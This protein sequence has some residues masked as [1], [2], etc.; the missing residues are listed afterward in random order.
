MNDLNL[1]Q[2]SNLSIFLLMSLILILRY[3]ISSGVFHYWSFTSHKATGPTFIK[4]DIWRS[5]QSSLVFAAV[6]TVFI[7]ML[8]NG[9]TQVYFN[10]S[11]FAWWYGPLSLILFLILQDTYFYWTHRLMH[12]YSFKKYHFAHHESRHPTAWTSFAFH[13]LEALI[14]AIFLPLFVAVIPIHIAYF[15]LALF[16]MTVFGITNHL[17][18]EIYPLALEKKLYI[19]T[20][21]HHNRHHH[22]VN[23]NFGLFFTFWDLLMGTE[24]HDKN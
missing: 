13:P 8:K 14:Q 19:I 21:T 24:Y 17:G 4:K 18:R 2:L 10:F 7:L 1:P 16:I 15:F 22:V 6:S 12:V 23:K 11:D 3:F 20:S 5:I 9:H